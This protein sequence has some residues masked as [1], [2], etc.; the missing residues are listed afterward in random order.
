MSCW[1]TW[2]NC[3]NGILNTMNTCQQNICSNMYITDLNN[4]NKIFSFYCI[5]LSPVLISVEH[6]FCHFFMEG[7]CWKLT[8]AGVQRRAGWH[9]Q[10]KCDS[11][12]WQSWQETESTWLRAVWRDNS[13]QT[14]EMYFVAVDKG[15]QMSRFQQD[16]PVFQGGAPFSDKE[17][18]GRQIVPFFNSV[19]F[20]NWYRFFIVACKQQLELRCLE[21]KSSSYF[22]KPLHVLL[23]A[24]L[25]LVNLNLS[26]N[27]AFCGNATHKLGYWHLSLLESKA[28]FVVEIIFLL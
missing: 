5:A 25:W 21:W 4:K 2:S 27:R 19:F 7:T 11:D 1:L 18:M 26:S 6:V 10:G 22:S 8:R 13:Y 14:G 15:D 12:I 28:A 20:Y 16:S 3:S 24:L 17:K 23:S 9:Y